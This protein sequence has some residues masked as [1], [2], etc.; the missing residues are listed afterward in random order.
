MVTFPNQLP[1]TSNFTDITLFLQKVLACTPW[2]PYTWKCRSCDY[3]DMHPGPAIAKHI[4]IAL[5]ERAIQQGPNTIHMS[6]ALNGRI[7]DNALCPH[8]FERS[9]SHT[10]HIGIP[11][12]LYHV[13]QTYRN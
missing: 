6:N 11:F 7:N 8:C 3:M 10:M 13:C 5:T 9:Q 2:V 4:S 12:R 1:T